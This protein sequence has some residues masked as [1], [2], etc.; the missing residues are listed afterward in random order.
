MLICVG[1]LALSYASSENIGKFLTK[2]WYLTV[3][4][5]YIALFTYVP[6]LLLSM[7]KTITKLIMKTFEFWFKI[8]YC[9]RWWICAYLYWDKHDHT[10]YNFLQF[11][12]FTCSLVFCLLDAIKIPSKWQTGVISLVT[13]VFVS[14]AIYWNKLQF[15]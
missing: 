7:N 12:I 1:I 15:I 2:Y 8:I 11:A 3:M 9:I 4:P 5:F 14:N 6:L 10:H 13:I